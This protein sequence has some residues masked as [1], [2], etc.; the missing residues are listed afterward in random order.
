MNY[1][2]PLVDLPKEV[3]KPRKRG[4]KGGV[5]QRLKRNRKRLPLPIVITGN[6]RSLNNKTEELNASVKY[7]SEYKFAS[8]LGITETWFTENS[9]GA[10][11]DGFTL[12]RGDRTR[13][14]CKQRGGGVC[15]Y[16]NERYCHP[17][18]VYHTGSICNPDV[19]ILTVTLR[20]YYLPR[21]FPKVT[22]NIVYVPPSAN[23][24]TAA[25]T[26]AEMVNQ[27]QTKSPDGVVLVMGDVN[28]CLVEHH[29]PNFEQ[30]VDCKTR[31]DR[32]LDKFY[33][34]V[35]GAYK[36][37]PLPKLGNSDHLMVHLLPLYRP[38]LKTLP[39]VRKTVNIWDESSCESLRGCFECTD[40]NVFYE[41]CDNLDDLND[42]ISEYVRFCES[43]CIK[44]KTIKCFP[45]N[46]PWVTKEV[47]YA[48]NEKKRA[49][50]E[51]DEVKKRTSQY[52]L[53]KK[54]KE[55]RES[56]K[57]KMKKSFECNDMKD[58]WNRMK[59]VIGSDNKGPQINPPNGQTYADELNDFYSRFD[60]DSTPD[61]NLLFKNINFNSFTDD[62]PFF[63]EDDTHKIFKSLKV[64]KSQGPDK[65][66]PIV[67]KTCSS[68][69]SIPYTH[70]FNESIK[71][72]KLPTIWRTSEIVPVPKKRKITVLNDLR[73]VAVTSVLVKCLEKLV[74]SI[75]LPCVAPFQDVYQFAYKNKRS[76]DDA[77]AVFTDLIYK[78][79]DS[80]GNYCRTLFVD[81]SSA[82]NTIQPRI[83]IEKLLHM[84]VNKHICAWILEFLTNRPQFVRLRIDSKTFFSETRTI[85]IGSPQGTCISPALF[86][87][88]TD[89]CRSENDLVKI[90]K[91]ADD[92]AILALMNTKV[93]SDVFLCQISR[94]VSWCNDHSLQLN[95]SKT[96]EIIF[97]FRKNQDG[98]DAVEID[99][100]VVERVE[101]YKYLGVTVN[102]RLDWSEHASNVLSK[103]DQRL[104]FVRKLKYFN[105]DNTLI[106]LF[107]RSAIQSLI[108]FCVCVWGGNLNCREACKFDRVARRVFKMTNIEQDSFLQIFN[109]SC[110]RKIEKIIKDKDHPL[111]NSVTFSSRSNRPIL[112]K[113]NRERYRMSFVPY[114]IKLFATNFKR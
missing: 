67:L 51:K 16:V 76:V 79:L 72:H 33:C 29:L 23:D 65:I 93:N 60:K 81:F 57:E 44:T 54:I 73:P 64:N 14:S 42:V 94:F 111:S 36:C 13:E 75:L 22:V 10:N 3:T 28:T 100:Q 59:K 38:K 86:T 53:E 74:L 48:I 105:I 96:K 80:P 17:N 101:E 45:N 47:K 49:F 18:N 92:T 88:Y 110:L 112:L 6:S 31:G 87:I 35:K 62:P 55:G 70:I 30:F 108:S 66:S 103:I 104:Y 20:P 9:T 77:I 40:W 43:M 25:E 46:K 106:S 63:K 61:D 2:K 8:I 78:H 34:N 21:E 11:I 27:Q 69:L 97:D 90:I 102:E 15:L 32:T 50:G 85:N 91:F 82:F 71:Q 89:E 7:F 37:K 95:V 109:K 26:I 5:K 24:E 107:Y 98:H 52:Q 99:G 41:S 12:I 68:Q 56:Y 58:V 113:T 1:F 39:V 83:L 19:E 4:R 114:S 84:N